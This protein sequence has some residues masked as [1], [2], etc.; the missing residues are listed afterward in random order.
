MN[1][2]ARAVAGV[3]LSAVRFSSKR[4]L[5]LLLGLMCL[6]FAWCF[7]TYNTGES[8]RLEEQLRS[9]RMQKVEIARQLSLLKD[10]SILL[11][12]IRKHPATE[13]FLIIELVEAVRTFAV[14]NAA[15]LRNLQ[16]L[17]L[18]KELPDRINLD[19]EIHLSRAQQL[20]ELFDVIQI[21]SDWRPIDI[22]GCSLVRSHLSAGVS[23]TCSINVFLFSEFELD[24]E[25]S[26]ERGD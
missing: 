13:E 14:S 25:V 5:H 9:L 8:E 6:S 17:P 7:Y 20:I 4:S 16:V 3:R 23:T 15:T 1:T 11:A 26:V 22:R 10:N 18:A 24:S 12:N 2:N 19:F 21:A